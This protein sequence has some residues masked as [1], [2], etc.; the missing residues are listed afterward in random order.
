MVEI[1]GASNPVIHHTKKGGSQTTDPFE[2]VNGSMGLTGS[3]DSTVILS[4]DPDGYHD[5]ILYGRGRDL[6]EFEEPLSFDGSRWSNVTGT[7]ALRLSD[8]RR[9]IVEVL[10]SGPETGM[11]VQDIAKALEKPRGTV[12]RLLGKMKTAGEVRREARGIYALP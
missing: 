11:G 5:G 10:G 2:A 7:D 6:A 9:K 4:H 8:E 1:D 12:D 3:A